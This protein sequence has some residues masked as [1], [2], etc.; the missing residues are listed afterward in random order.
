MNRKSLDLKLPVMA[1]AFIG[2]IVLLGVQWLNGML[3]YPQHALLAMLYLLFAIGACALGA[4][5]VERMGMDKVIHTLAWFTLIGSTLCALAGLWQSVAGPNFF[6]MPLLGTRIYGNTGQPNHFADYVFC[7]LTSLVYLTMRDTTTPWHRDAQAAVF[8][9]VL[10]PAL[11]LSGSRAVWVYFVMLIAFLCWRQMWSGL[12]TAGFALG[13]YA[14][15]EL[16]TLHTSR[17]AGAILHASGLGEHSR[18]DMARDAW[19]MFVSHP[20]LGVGFRQYAYE[21]FM[22]G[23]T[24]NEEAISDNAHN[25][26]LNV[27]AEFGIAGLLVLLVP[28]GWWLLKCNKTF[29]PMMVL[30]I[31]GA[32]SMVEYPLYYTYFLGMAAFLFGATQWT[33]SRQ[34][35]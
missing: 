13:V 21:H 32:H 18:I 25:L 4:Q 19:Q 10:A 15:T 30:L 14:V 6:V 11:A 33:N 22:A 31:I 7:G 35:S 29:W 23:G 27:G 16:V 28:L 9:I 20:W 24:G 12:K 26:L 34:P 8:S 1:Y 5:M 3:S 17:G 2:F